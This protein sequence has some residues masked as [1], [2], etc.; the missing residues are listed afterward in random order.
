MN[1]ELSILTLILEA[2]PLVQA[3]M[4]ILILASLFS[5]G[6]VVQRWLL[7]RLVHRRNMQFEEEFWSG[8]T[9]ASCTAL[10]EMTKRAWRQ[11]FMPATTNSFACSAVV[12]PI[13]G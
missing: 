1:S 6:L 2:T 8:V 10:R 11:S 4:L 13:P 9:S 7:Y 12:V 3:V 5:W